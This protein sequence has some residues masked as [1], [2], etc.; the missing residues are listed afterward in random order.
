MP[1][2]H[3]TSTLN[4]SVAPMTI[5]NIYVLPIPI[6][7]TQ[8]LPLEKTAKHARAV[9][10]PPQDLRPKS[11]AMCVRL[12]QSSCMYLYTT[13][14][15]T[16][17]SATAALLARFV[18][19]GFISMNHPY[20]LPPRANGAQVANT[21]LTTK[22]RQRTQPNDTAKKTIAFL[23]T[24]VAGTTTLPSPA[25]CAQLEE[26]EP[27]KMPRQSLCIPAKRARS[28]FTMGLMAMSP[29]T[30]TTK[31]TIVWCVPLGNIRMKRM[32]FHSAVHA[33]LENLPKTNN[34]SNAQLVGN[35]KSRDKTN[36]WIVWLV[37]IKT[38][39]VNL[40]VSP[41]FRA[42]MKMAL[43]RQVVKLVVKDN[44]KM[45]LATKPV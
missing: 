12:G 33:L 3:G 10:H 40:I 29:E 19:P 1:L 21:F 35:K 18:L 15:T 37:S 22:S 39:Q 11:I 2:S 26:S 7:K 5:V 13:V 23:A 32:V 31:T 24:E 30:G 9:K 44:I 34:A 43:A 36:A 20:T 42:R 16:A 4:F 17:T 45:R 14:A 38:N 41:A 8:A 28:V 25:P 6:R 27:P